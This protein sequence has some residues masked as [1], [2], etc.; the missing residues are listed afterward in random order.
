[1]SHISDARVQ[2]VGELNQQ[3]DELE[4][5]IA[6]LEQQNQLKASRIQ[7]LEAHLNTEVH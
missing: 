3:I 1:M 4:M 2:E 6:Q 5:D 7:Q